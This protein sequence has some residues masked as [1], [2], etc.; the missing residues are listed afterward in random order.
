MKKSGK[1]T[2][3]EPEPV[4]AGVGDTTGKVQRPQAN[5]HLHKLRLANVP[6][7]PGVSNKFQ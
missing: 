6:H 5:V 4:L 7:S 3:A 1:I 2:Q